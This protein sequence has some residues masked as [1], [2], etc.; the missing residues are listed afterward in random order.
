MSV[1]NTY[2]GRRDYLWLGGKE[3][4][5]NCIIWVSSGRR[6]DEYETCQEFVLPMC[7]AVDKYDVKWR[8]D[9]CKQTRVPICEK[10]LEKAMCTDQSSCSDD[11][12]CSSE[13]F[14]TSSS[15]DLGKMTC[16]CMDGF[17]GNGSVCHDIDECKTSL[18]NCHYYSKCSNTHGSYECKCVFG[19]IGDGKNCFLP[20]RG[21]FNQSSTYFVDEKEEHS[22]FAAI[23]KC[24]EFGGFLV[25]FETED[26]WNFVA[27]DLSMQWSYFKL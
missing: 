26:E 11:A 12:L 1:E 8:L 24:Q 7:L 19:R 14:Q 17:Y 9:E 13:T 15:D 4:A 27:N 20:I 2:G 10:K 22:C 25:S 5:Q 6:V 21:A 23:K 3:N 18:D 16:H